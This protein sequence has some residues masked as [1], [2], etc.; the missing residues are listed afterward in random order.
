MQHDLRQTTVFIEQ[1]QSIIE[2]TMLKHIA[3]VTVKPT[4]EQPIL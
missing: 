3:I 1:T 2:K 4:L